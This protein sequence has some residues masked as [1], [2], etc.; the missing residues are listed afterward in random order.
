MKYSSD[1]VN[2]NLNVKEKIDKLYSNLYNQIDDIIALT[3]QEKFNKSKSI[4]Y[5]MSRL[6]KDIYPNRSILYLDGIAF[7]ELY[8]PNYT[9]E[10]CND[11]RKIKLEMF[12]KK[13]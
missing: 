9:L 12:Y 5:Y 4:F 10:E 8:E 13:L 7:L 11:F 2:I 1:I 6:T 3:F